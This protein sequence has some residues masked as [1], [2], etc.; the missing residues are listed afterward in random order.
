MQSLWS[1]SKKLKP[2]QQHQPRCS[3]F[4][5][6]ENAF[7]NT[8]AK[9][10][11]DEEVFELH[12]RYGDLEQCVRDG[13]IGCRV[14]R[15][16]LLALQITGQQVA[17]IEREDEPVYVRFRRRSG[18]EAN[19]SPRP[20]IQAF[21]GQG[22]D[23]IKPVS[24]ALESTVHKSLPLQVKRLD[25]VTPEIISWL[26]DCRINHKAQCGN[27]S[28]SKHN[29]RRLI[30]IVT[31]SELKLI[32][33]E[34]LPKFD[35]IALSYCWGSGG[36]SANTT[37]KNLSSRQNLFN[38][39]DLP[40][41]I[42]DSLVLVKRL[43]LNY[44]WVDQI[45][46]VQKSEDDKGEDWD[47]DNSNMYVVYGNALLT[48]SACSSENS[49]DGL[50]R[51]RKAW[52]YPVLPFYFNGQWLVNYD[53]SLKEV[54]ARA[55]L[56]G[57]AWTLQEERLSP[58]LLY[59]CEQ[60]VYWSCS[61]KQHMEV[62]TDCRAQ[63]SHNDTIYAPQ[64]DYNWL[65]EAQL[66]LELRFQGERTSLHR[67]WHGLIEDYCLRSMT[68]TSDRFR[69]ISGLA[70]QYLSVYLKQ[71]NN[72]S[73]QEYL[74]GLWRLTFADDLAWAVSE[75]GDPLSSLIALAPS[76]SWASLPL[77]TRISTTKQSNQF[78]GIKLLEVP[79]RFTYTQGAA[80]ELG[81]IALNACRKGAEKKRV[82]VR[83]HLQKVMNNASK[84]IDWVEI[85]VEHDCGGGYS[86][87]KYI[88]QHVHARNYKNGK[89][90]IYEPNK[91]PINGQL[92]Y[93][94]PPADT[95]DDVCA[96]DTYVALGKEKD[97]YGLEIGDGTMMLLQLKVYHD[98]D[99][100][101]GVATQCLRQVPVYRRVGICLGVREAFFEGA[102]PRDHFLE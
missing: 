60:R 13:C 92:D 102:E 44:L 9:N 41:T 62:G 25:F 45:C 83:G 33:A 50:F 24:I 101:T 16:S 40:K 32:D 82:L 26:D 2:N 95:E 17:T 6:L 77:C 21:L 53:M 80:A 59:F 8:R 37:S 11:Q 30:Q 1:S 74:A 98:P 70:V 69:A 61:A 84:R 89:I 100:N 4:R 23:N 48:L 20:S 28:W 87:S 91:R 54:R 67:E 97:L 19:N 93:L 35:Y 27:L 31:D 99:Q 43:G 86:F 72:L 29:P 88:D 38:A 18:V 5:R 65:S 68:R 79:E 94:T 58:R 63:S 3:N 64:D 52:V 7:H 36:T 66:F 57:R 47:L 85:E 96:P 34:D 51:Q 56:S 81:A 71:D 14:I 55:P 39:K 22:E 90:I 46:I 73:G 78:S 75:A 10:A 15:H 49:T 12:S 42:Q 76:W